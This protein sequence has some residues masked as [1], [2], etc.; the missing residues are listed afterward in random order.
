M[1]T[2][3][4]Q[5]Q[6]IS[7]ICNNLL[8]VDAVDRKRD[9]MMVRWYGVVRRCLFGEMHNTNIRIKVGVAL[10]DLAKK[11]TLLCHYHNIYHL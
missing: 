5:L 10:R 2:I 1:I 9:G 7:V 3:E 4:K 6:R 8:R 11:L